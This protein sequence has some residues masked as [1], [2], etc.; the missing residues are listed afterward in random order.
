MIMLTIRASKGSKRTH[1]L[2][3]VPFRIVHI[4]KTNWYLQRNSGFTLN[5]PASSLNNQPLDGLRMLIQPPDGYFFTP[6][7][8]LLGGGDVVEVVS[9]FSTPAG[10]LDYSARSVDELMATGYLSYLRLTWW[11]SNKN[12]M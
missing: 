7:E 2:D 8:F 6:K 9:G 5:F 1:K 12:N 11:E 4:Y 10:G 3:A